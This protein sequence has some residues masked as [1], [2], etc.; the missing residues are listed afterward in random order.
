MKTAVES[1]ETVSADERLRELQRA[2]EKSR[3]DM[4]SKLDYAKKQG[5][6]EG[7]INITERMLKHGIDIEIIIK[8]T[9]LSLDKIKEIENRLK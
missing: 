2:R 9:G 5:R 6:Q 4:V 7:I 3:L 1:L 8:V